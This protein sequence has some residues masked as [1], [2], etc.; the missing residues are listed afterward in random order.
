MAYPQTRHGSTVISPHSLVGRRRHAVV[1]NTLLYQL[2]V[3]K[4]TGR[5]DAFKLKWHKVYE[6]PPVVWPIPNHQFWDSDVAKWIEGACYV[7]KQ[8]SLPVVDQAVRELV[9]MIRSAQQPDGYLNIHYTVVEPGKR[10]TNLRDMHELYNAG[11][12]IEAALAHEDVYGDQKLLE[13][14]LKYVDLFCVTFGPGEDQLHG[15]PGHPEIELALLRLYEHT[16]DPKHLSLARYF[17]TERGNP[18][19]ANG[20][21]FYD[22]EARRRGDDPHTQP[23]YYPRPNSFWYARDITTAETTTHICIGINK[24]TCR[25]LSKQ[26][27]KVTPCGPCICSQR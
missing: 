10:F 23:A 20:R 14:M 6:E 24:P 8:Q 22:D 1:A 18:N 17:I 21:H 5:Y 2:D 3:L 15:Y 11:H 16:K 4:K 27:S 19:G 13:P 12:L 9:D 26:V 7:L 25:S